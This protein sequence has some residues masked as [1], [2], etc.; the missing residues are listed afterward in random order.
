ML[1]GLVSSFVIWDMKE[2][3]CET[4][5]RMRYGCEFELPYG[6]GMEV[7]GLKNKKN[8]YVI[9]DRIIIKTFN[10]SHGLLKFNAQSANSKWCLSSPTVSHRHIPILCKFQTPSSH[11]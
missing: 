5:S 4:W 9:N 7:W 11:S 6:V 8:S 10:S 2:D 1:Y 3:F